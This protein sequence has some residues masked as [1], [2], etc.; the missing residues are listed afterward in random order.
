MGQTTPE[1]VASERFDPEPLAPA[2]DH[3]LNLMN[4]YALATRCG[5]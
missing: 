2:A 4:A 1:F 3:P 5:E